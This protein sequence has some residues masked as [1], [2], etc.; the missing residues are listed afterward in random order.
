MNQTES[1]GNPRFAVTV[2]IIAEL[3][4]KARAAGV[5]F[6]YSI[7]GPANAPTEMVDPSFN[8]RDASEWERVNGPDKFRGSKL[9]EKLKARNIEK[10]IICGHS[11][12][13]FTLNTA[14]GLA[15]RGIDVIVPVDC[16]ASNH[17]Y[18]SYMEQYSVWHL[19]RGGNGVAPRV[20]ITRSSLVGFRPAPTSTTSSAR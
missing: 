14:T 7:A 19:Y 2:P 12:Q 6:W 10:A 5:M 8:P 11:F 20:T 9:E 16:S 15:L 4:K 17:P 13:G 1:M 18:P 3:A